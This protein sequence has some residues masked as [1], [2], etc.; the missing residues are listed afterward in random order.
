MANGVSNK[1]TFK[2]YDVGQGEL[3]PPTAA[4]LIPSNHMVRIVNSTLD[5]LNLEPILK[6]YRGG[7]ASRY[8]PLMLLKIIVYGYLNHVC[9]S[10]KIAKALRREYIFSLVIRK[11]DA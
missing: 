4:D 11:P 6:Q 7:G 8:S 5:Q 3:I 10:R 2:P 1:V 9:S